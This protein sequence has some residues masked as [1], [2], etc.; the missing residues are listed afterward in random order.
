MAERIR[1]VNIEDEVKSSYLDYAMSVIISRA[2][3][4]VRDG[5][6][7]VQRRILWA[8]R[9]LGLYS[10]RP[11]RK[12]AKICGDVSGNYHPHGESVVYPAL[13]RLAQD[14]V[15]R[16][17]LVDGQGN[18]GSVDGDPPAAMRYTEARM[19]VFAEEMLRDV[20]KE[21]VDFVPNY[22]GTRSEPV[23]LPASLPNLLVNGCSGIAVGMATEIPPHN[24]GEIVDGLVALLEN[25]EITIEELM[26]YI[27]GPD[28]PTGGVIYGKGGIKEAYLTG[29]G[30]IKV[31]GKAYIE[32]DKG[33]RKRIVISEIPYMVNK[34]RLL[35][36]IGEL[37]REKKIEGISD[38]RDESD[39]DGMSI[40]VEVK[41]GVPPEIVLN[42]LFKSTPLQASIGIILLALVEGRPRVLNLK[43]LMESFLKF[44]EE[45]VTRRLTFE[46]KKARERAHILEGLKIALDHLDEVISTIRKSS[47]VEIAKEN[48]IKKFSLTEVQAQAILDMRLQRLTGLERKKVEEDYLSVIK[49]IVRL[50]TLLSSPLQI[51][52][53]IKEEL[54]KLKEKYADPR[55]TEI[56]EEE[57]EL[58]VEDLIPQEEMVVTLTDSG[59]I[60]RLPLSTYRKQER[61]GKGLKGM[62]AKEEDFVKS[63]MVTLTHD[64]LLCFS[65]LG[66]VY[67]LKT[68]QIPT[69]GRLS[70]GKALV[71]LLPFQEGERLTA[72]LRV[73]D[74][75]LQRFVFMVTRK[76]KVKMTP[77]SAFSHP[78]STGII[79]MTL[80]EKDELKEVSLVKG[81]EEV[82]LISKLGKGI[83]FTLKE[84]RSMGRAAG[85]VRGMRLGDEDEIVGMIVLKE[86]E[87]LF[88][89]SE[90]GYGKRTE[91]S[92]FPLQRRGGKGVIAVKITKK[93]G[94]IIGAAGVKEKDSII[95]LTERGMVMRFPVSSVRKMGRQTV[96]VKLISLSEGDRVSSIARVTE[97]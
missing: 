49:E 48:L 89:V 59:Y 1:A 22:D 91:Y 68:F 60:K 45:V 3:P 58:G 47:T 27:P 96:G 34:S 25:P 2:L 46:L 69:A 88:V 41:R 81:G 70:R 31:R 66:K 19:S 39:K 13:V 44:R 56:V 90:R 11:F 30:I 75:N 16:Y 24:L 61:G 38:L 84:I 8:M 83:R 92:L 65:N 71:N 80:E 15:M 82:I 28:F 5:L 57:P 94:R 20:D 73:E 40:V 10:N 33:E 72:F 9:D 97:I 95:L 7:P 37:V 86:G 87:S 78:R 52:N 77:L 79:A 23:V 12:C 14:F 43:E 64:Y 17:P 50:E 21:T 63:L 26:E 76:G 36:S 42:Q 67:W 18:F 53:L 62:D 51:K 55:R 35:E 32:G 93:N 85:G 6:K 29:K 74:F 4:D 54:L